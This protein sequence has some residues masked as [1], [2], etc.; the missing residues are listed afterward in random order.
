MTGAVL[1]TVVARHPGPA[2]SIPVRLRQLPSPSPGGARDDDP[3]VVRRAPTS[4]STTRPWSP[5][6]SASA[7]PRVE[8]DAWSRCSSRCRAG[9]VAPDD[10]GRGRARRLPA[11]QHLA[12]AGAQRHR[13]GRAH[14]PRP[15]AAL[16]GRAARPSPWPPAPPTSSSTSAPGSA[17]RAGPRALA[18][19]AAAVPRRRR[20]ARGQQRRR[21]AGAGRPCALAGG[22]KVVVARGELVEI[23]DGFRI[24]E[25][26]ESAGRRLREVGTTNRVRLEDYAAAVDDRTG[27][28]AQGAPLQLPGRGL[29]LE[30]PVSAAGTRSAAPVVADIG[31]GL[32]APTPGC[33]TEPDAA[34]PCAPAPTSSPRRGDKLLGGPQCG[35]L[36]GRPTL[37]ERLRRHPF[38]RALRVDKLTLAALEATLTGPPP[39]VAEMLADRPSEPLLARARRIAALLG[40]RAARPSPSDG[41]ASAGAARRAWC[42]RAPR[43]PCRSGWPSPCAAASRPWSGRRAR[44]SAAPR[45]ARPCRP[46]TTSARRRRRRA[47]ARGRG[48]LTCTSSPRLGTWTT[49]SPRWSAR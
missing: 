8:G 21:R 23:G 43:S 20:R 44:R 33:P 34:T 35:L 49:A 10:V 9:E 36:L 32:L 45:P 1:K 15:G 6:P 16:G 42:C 28:R 13:G 25:L 47:L 48:R 24:P 29:H 3:G 46:R 11:R 40:D 38:A 5:R 22:R 7:G 14:Q 17:D 27:L 4:C 41:G 31:S 12:A 26:L 30:V 2:G 18:A 19:L 39:P 37:V